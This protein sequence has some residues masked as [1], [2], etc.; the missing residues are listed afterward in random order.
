MCWQMA[1]VVKNNS[2]SGVIQTLA[3]AFIDS[4]RSESAHSITPSGVLI[5]ETDLEKYGIIQRPQDEAVLASS[6]DE[7]DS[8]V[9]PDSKKRRNKGFSFARARHSTELDSVIQEAAQS[10]GCANLDQMPGLLLEN[11]ELRTRNLGLRLYYASMYY[12]F[13]GFSLCCFALASVAANVAVFFIVRWL[14]LNQAYETDANNTT[15]MIVGASSAVGLDLCA[16]WAIW[17]VGVAQHRMGRAL[18]V[19]YEEFEDLVKVLARTQAG[20]L[21]Y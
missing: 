15:A 11:D 12:M 4:P 3:S 10:V 14:F 13:F 9:S 5:Q 2:K 16:G 8:P 1:G 20:L 18:I 21:R 7:L 19:K 17:I 6:G